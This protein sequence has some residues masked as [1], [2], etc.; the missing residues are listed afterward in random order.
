[1]LAVMQDGY[2]LKWASK[3]LQNA[4]KKFNQLTLK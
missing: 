2:V 4:I 3:E 1:M